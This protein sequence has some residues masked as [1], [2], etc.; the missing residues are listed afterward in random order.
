M[1]FFLYLR[2]MTDYVKDIERLLYLHD[3]VVVPGFGGFVCR[4]VP[5][6][7]EGRGGRV[8]PPRR[9]V[10][11]NA[12]LR[13]DD[14]LLAGRVARREGVSHE[15][16]RRRVEIFARGTLEQLYAGKRV[17]FGGIGW[18]AMEGRYRLVFHG[19]GRNFLAGA[20]GMEAVEGREPRGGMVMLDGGGLAGR[21]LKYVAGAAA[22]AGIVVISQ[23]DIFRGEGA[24]AGMQP[25]TS[26][27]RVKAADT[28]REARVS[29][30][31]DFVDFAPEVEG[32]AEGPGY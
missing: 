17:E 13:E 11:F 8:L 18:F 1:V 27:E 14:G 10:V 16:A 28:E 4:Y 31:C 29:P 22:V 25:G 15:Q 30:A 20:M 2:G 23:Q 9:E 24:R 26:V 21:L 19:S 32:W 12:R 6:R 7:A 5:A 3:C